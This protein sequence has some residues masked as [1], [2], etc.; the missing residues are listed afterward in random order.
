MLESVTFEEWL[1]YGLDQSWCGPAVCV[2]HDGLPM[3]ADEEQEMYE[4]DPCIHAIRLYEDEDT[5]I[6]VE[7]NHSPSIW[8]ATNAGYKVD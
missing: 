7:E 3:T 1:Q 8:R 5:K 4:L 2:T 6:K